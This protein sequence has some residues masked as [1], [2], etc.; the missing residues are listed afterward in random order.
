[1]LRN[2]EVL[3]FGDGKQMRDYVY[4]GDVVNANI[5]SLT[6]GKNQVINIGTGKAVSVNELAKVIGRST[7]YKK[8]MVHKP[9]RDGELFKSFLNIDKAKA[10]LSW[11]PEVNMEQ[12]IKLSV[13]YFRERI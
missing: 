4:V 2:E 1:M 13:A 9:K 8:K 10:V 5:K 3:V 7:G 12:G 6:K 11:T